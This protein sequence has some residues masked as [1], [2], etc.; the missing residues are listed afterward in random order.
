MKSTRYYWNIV[1][2]GV[3]CHILCK[4]YTKLTKTVSRN[5]SDR[6]I[7]HR[8]CTFFSFLNIYTVCMGSVFVL[9][10]TIVVFIL[11]LPFCLVIFF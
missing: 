7:A 3:K 10:C 8:V 6:P 11:Y 2:S 4:H 1:E 5:Q 9:H